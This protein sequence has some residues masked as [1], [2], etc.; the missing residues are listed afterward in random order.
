MNIRRKN[1]ENKDVIN[2]RRKK[3]ENVIDLKFKKVYNISIK[4]RRWEL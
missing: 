3:Y 1:Y 4:K 2:I